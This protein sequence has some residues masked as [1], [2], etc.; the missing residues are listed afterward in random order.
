MSECLTVT[1]GGR[2]AQVTSL[3]KHILT[4]FAIVDVIRLFSDGLFIVIWI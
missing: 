3:H 2:A 4:I 1:H